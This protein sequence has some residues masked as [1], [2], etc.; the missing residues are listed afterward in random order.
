MK[1]VKKKI[2]CLWLL[3]FLLLFFNK[4]EIFEVYIQTEWHICMWIPENS[5][6]K[7]QTPDINYRGHIGLLE[8]WEQQSVCQWQIGVTWRIQ[9]IL[10]LKDFFFTVWKI[11]VNRNPFQSLLQ[12]NTKLIWLTNK[13]ITW[14]SILNN[15]FVTKL[16]HICGLYYSKR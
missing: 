12:K 1:T 15:D 7:L 5:F 3:V 6:L 9:N 4:P 8:P 11:L 16:S 14:T 10:Q 2:F 13:L